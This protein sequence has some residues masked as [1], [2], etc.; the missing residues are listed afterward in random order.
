MATRMR[1]RSTLRFR[2]NKRAT[3]WTAAL[4]NTTVFIPAGS[5]AI[6]PLITPSN[7]VMTRMRN[8]VI[9]RIVG[10]VSVWY[11]IAATI[12]AASPAVAIAGAGIQVLD[13]N[14]TAAVANIPRPFTDAA[15]SWMWWRGTTMVVPSN[16]GVDTFMQRWSIDIKSRRKFDTFNDQLALFIENSA[17]SAGTIATN[18]QLRI[19]VSD[20]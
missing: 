8:P 5:L 2:S 9:E 3:E 14:Q 7:P 19:L 20:R 6:A 16:N 18:S 10:E 15:D 1:R 17:N 13:S 4:A 12:G 11:N